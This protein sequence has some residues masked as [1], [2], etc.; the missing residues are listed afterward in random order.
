MSKI[1]A[2]LGPTGVGKTDLSIKLA[3][4]LNAEIINCDSMQVYKEFNIG[5]AKITKEEK[6]GI[7]HHMLD[8]V[9][10][11]DHFNAY[12]YQVMARKIIED[13]TNISKNIII[14]GGTGLYL[15]AVLYDYTFD[16]KENKNKKLYDFTLVALTRPREELY[17]R[18]NKRVD[19]MIENGLLNEVKD[20]YDKNINTR[21]I[22]TAIGYKELYE[23]FD[24]HKTLDEALDKIRQNSRNYAKRQYTFFNNQF[25]NINWFDTSIKSLDEITMEIINNS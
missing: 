23:Y 25:D 2:I 19:I 17:D 10:V 18:I 5:V 7:I 15:K 16:E 14:V 11:N 9:S 24:K 4:E 3:K 8:I 13:L 22:N 1:I 6:E 12:D 21:A 20:L